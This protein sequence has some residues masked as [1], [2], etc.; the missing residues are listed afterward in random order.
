[1][2]PGLRLRISAGR[3]RLDGRRRRLEIRSLEP[4]LSHMRNVEKPG[5]AAHLI[6]LFDDTRRILQRHLVAR[7]GNELR[8]QLAVQRVQGRQPRL[9]GGM[10]CGLRLAHHGP[11]DVKAIR[12]RGPEPPLSRDLRDFARNLRSSSPEGDSA[13]NGPTPSVRRQRRRLLSRV[14][15]S[16]GPFCLRV[17]GAVAPSAP[18]L[19][20]L[21]RTFP[22]ARHKSP[23]GTPLSTGAGAA[24]AGI[25]IL[26]RL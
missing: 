16:R 24:R 4:R 1:M 7:E 8:A 22:S 10:V 2:R 21:S 19:A 15:S 17:S 25:H 26:L 18:A 9:S 14:L 23:A 12:L 13:T 11:S 20:G 5:G 6:V 3:Q